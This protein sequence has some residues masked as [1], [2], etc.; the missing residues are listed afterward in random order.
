MSDQANRLKAATH[1]VSKACTV[2]RDVQRELERVQ[3]ITKDD[4]SPVTVADFASQAIVAHELTE[5][6]GP[7]NLVAEEAAD[8]LRAQLADGNDTVAN[9]VLEAV[10][11]AWPEATMDEV[12]DAIDIG[13]GDPATDTMHG[14]WTLDPIDGTKGFLRGGQYAVALAWVENG[15]P[16]VGALGCPNLSKDFSRPL[17]DPDPTGTIY[18]AIAAEGLAEIA[19]NDPDGD[20]LPIKRLELA[21]DEPLRM[22]ESVESAHTSHSSSAKIMETMGRES[23]SVRLDSQ[24]KY[25]VVARGQADIYLRMPTRPGYVERIWDHAAGAIMATESGC[26]VTDVNGQTLDFSHGRGL[27]KNKGVVVA[28]TRIHGDLIKAI[29]DLGLN[30]PVQ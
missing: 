14:F 27:E 15:S 18:L 21:E 28:P 4:R 12:L 13:G 8:E 19:A 23:A 7:I 3:K 29:A 5:R 24:C 25:A 2:C 1:A 6:L 11:I 10:R 9:A 30:V 20:P 17:D 26:A 16:Q 22:C